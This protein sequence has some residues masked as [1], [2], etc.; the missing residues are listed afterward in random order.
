MLE[1]IVSFLR[2]GTLTIRLGEYFTLEPKRE[3]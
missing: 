3:D 1:G 2:A